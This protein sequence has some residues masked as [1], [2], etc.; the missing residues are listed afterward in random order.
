MKW[1]FFISTGTKQTISKILNTHFPWIHSVFEWIQLV[2][3]AV[4]S[5]L[6]CLAGGLERLLH[7]P[8]SLTGGWTLHRQLSSSSSHLQDEAGC[9]SASCLAPDDV[10]S[11]AASWDSDIWGLHRDHHHHLHSL[12]ENGTF[13]FTFSDVILKNS[14][15]KHQHSALCLFVLMFK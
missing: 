3:S 10:T 11:C 9:S 1:I 15:E 8:C 12:K 5:P 14:E 13:C 7:P 2:E 4:S 6:L